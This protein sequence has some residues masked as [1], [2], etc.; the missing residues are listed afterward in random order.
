MSIV[1]TVRG[2]VG[3]ADL[4]KVLMHEHVFVLGTDVR[5]NY[6]DYPNPWDEDAR[7]VDAVEKLRECKSRGID[8]IVDPTVIGL[9]RYI[10]RIQRV[11]EQVDLNIIVATG[12]YTYNEVPFQFH[13]TGPGLVFDA[14]EPL[15]ELFVK[16][17]REGIADTGVKAA[18]LKCAIEKQGPYAR[19]RAGDGRGRTCSSRD[20]VPITVHTNAHTQSGLWPRR[21]SRRSAPI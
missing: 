18:F 20:G 17:I 3:I 7:V 12:L 21:C 1:E 5:Q 16:D 6:P 13:Y 10:P 15:V 8:T 2:P 14:P 9:G 4:G 19:R 11:N